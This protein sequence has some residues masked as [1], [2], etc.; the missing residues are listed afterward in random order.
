[1]NE[2]GSI[3]QLLVIASKDRTQ[4]K[5]GVFMQDVLKFMVN[6]YRSDLSVFRKPE[7]NIDNYMN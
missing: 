7:N 6:Q 4:V 3:L 2:E 5:A 1:M